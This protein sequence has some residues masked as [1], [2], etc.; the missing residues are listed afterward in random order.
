MMVLLTW[1]ILIWGVVFVYHFACYCYGD[2]SLALNLIDNFSKRPNFTKKNVG[3]QVG[4]GGA[5]LIIYSCI[6]PFRRHRRVN[7][8]LSF[9]L[10]MWANWLWCM[11]CC[12]LYY[13]GSNGYSF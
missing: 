7:E 2:K 5:F 8:T 6:Y 3:L 4:A 11:S 9:D 10:F 1:F 12:L 13:Y